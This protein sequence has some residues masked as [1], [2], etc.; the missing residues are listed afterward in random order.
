MKK[1]PGKKVTSHIPYDLGITILVKLPLKSLKRLGCVCKS[2]GILF[3]NS[4]FINIFSNN[5]I[6][7]HGSHDDASLLLQVTIT[8]FSDTR[9]HSLYSLYGDS[10]INRV[11]LEWPNPFHVE[12]PYF[13]ILDSGSINGTLCLY[14]D[15]NGIFIIVIWNPI[16]KELKVIPRS[17]IEFVPSPYDQYFVVLHGFG[18]DHIQDDYKIIRYINV[19]LHSSDIYGGKYWEIYSLRSNSWRTLD[20]GM[21]GCGL[22]T[23]GERLYTLGMC[24]WISK[25]YTN[26]D[27][28][29]LVSFNLNGEIFNTTLIPLFMDAELDHEF[30]IHSMMLNGS[31]ATIS[32]YDDTTTFH[33]SILGELG[34]KE[35]WI[36]LFIV[37]PLSC[38]DHPIGVDKEGN[39]F[40]RKQNGELILLDLRTNVISD[41]GFNG[42]YTSQI[43]IL[44]GSFLP[45]GGINL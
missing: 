18:Y 40:F 12:N 9:Y 41:L 7:N 42:W 15:I 43:V 24:H 39:I 17:P 8:N 16:T 31:I 26:K 33:I 37:G 5:F 32:W 29:Y 23:I 36:K 35:S 13:Y 2:W 3:E 27:D 38:V 14:S 34:V 10:F 11:K 21:P 25:G 6:S 45:I 28:S 20:I 19:G 44:K 30:S 1:S 4:N 22:G